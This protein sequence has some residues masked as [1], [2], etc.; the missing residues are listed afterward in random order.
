MV[1]FILFAIATIG[2]TNILVHG[3]ILDEIKVCNWSIREWLHSVGF[4][5]EL[6]TCYECTG[7]WAGLFLGVVTVYCNQEHWASLVLYPFA[8]SVL[9]AFYSE[10]IFMIRSKTDFVVDEENGT[11]TQE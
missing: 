8:G 11:D 9:S 5:R 10:V 6:L 4:I 3:K 2:L 7:W 1:S